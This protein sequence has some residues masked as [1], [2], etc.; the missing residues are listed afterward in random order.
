MDNFKHV[1]QILDIGL[2][3]ELERAL[4]IAGITST[5]HI[6]RMTDDVLDNLKFKK[7]ANHFQYQGSR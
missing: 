3:S 4:Q 1:L 6:L 7:M 5:R 2:N